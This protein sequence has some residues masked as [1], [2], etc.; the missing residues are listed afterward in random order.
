MALVMVIDD[1]RLVGMVLQRILEPQGITCI[2]ARTAAE[3]FG[4]RGTKPLLREHRPDLILLD[5]MMP[6]MGGL[7]ILRKLKSMT[8]EQHIP[9]LM[10]S[11]SSSENNVTEAVNRGAEGFLSKP[12][13]AEKLLGEMAKIA[14]AHQIVALYQK[15][16]N[17]LDPDR[18]TEESR[19]DLFVG[20]ANLNYML[21]ILDGDQEMLHELIKVFVEDAPT[22]LAGIGNAI[23]AGNA[24]DLRQMAHTLKG[25]VS[26]LGAPR[27]T[28]KAR[29]LETMG[30]DDQMDGARPVYEDLCKDMGELLD[31]LTHWLEENGEG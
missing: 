14:E 1:S 12:I 2:Q 27:M 23:D 29:S 11:A 5:I 7:D 16:G 22:Q 25:S 31:G 13:D 3:V 6:D 19:E 9:V 30:R 8:D 15:L 26:N 24:K 20:P 17:Y 28:E 21:E 4:F 10:I 18:R